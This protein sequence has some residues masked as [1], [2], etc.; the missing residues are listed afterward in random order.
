MVSIEQEKE[1]EREEEQNCINFDAVLWVP[2]YW[3]QLWKVC[4]VSEQ[5]ERGGE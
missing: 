1:R 3:A 4:G 2:E 5:K